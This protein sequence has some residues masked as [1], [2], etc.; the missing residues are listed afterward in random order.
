MDT[1]STTRTEPKARRI[2]RLWFIVWFVFGL[3]TGYLAKEIHL[4]FDPCYIS[5]AKVIATYSHM[6]TVKTALKMFKV[7]NKD[8][9]STAEGITALVKTPSRFTKKGRFMQE[10]DIIDPWGTVFGYSRIVEGANPGFEL[11]SAGPDKE[12]FT[13]DDIIYRVR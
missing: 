13:Y 10:D 5:Q 2:R 8:L 4:E 12:H 9:P 1:E 3:I 7:A 6:G 11:W